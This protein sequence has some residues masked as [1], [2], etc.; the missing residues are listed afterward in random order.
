M[1]AVTVEGQPFALKIYSAAGLNDMMQTHGT[2]GLTGVLFEK[3]E[4]GS[5][6][7]LS[8]IGQKV[9]ARKAKGVYGRCNRIVKV[10]RVGQDSDRWFLLMD[11]LEVDPISKVDPAQMGGELVGSRVLG[12]RLCGRDCVIFM[13]RSGACI[14]TSGPRHLFGKQGK[15]ATDSPNTRSFITP[16]NS[17]DRMVGLA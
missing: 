5:P 3:A 17:I 11:L 13:W 6:Q 9:L 10:H 4:E 2:F 16:R 1:Y 15:A 14:S 8:D 12:G 7:G